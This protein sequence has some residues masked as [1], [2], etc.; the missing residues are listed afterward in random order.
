VL[1]VA[2]EAPSIAA[3]G[4]L[5][6]A[7]HRALP[8]M[9]SG[10]VERDFAGSGVTLRGWSCGA[11]GT[12]R[13]TLVYLHGIADNRGS[14]VGTIRKYTTQG[15]D[16]VA[17]DSRAHGRSGGE[18]CTYGYYEKDDLRRVIDTLP[19]GRVILMGTSLGAAVAIQTAAVDSRV[20]GVI[21]AE[22]FSNLEA[23]ARERVPFFLSERTIRKAFAIAESRGAFRIAD[24][25]PQEAARRVRVP[26]LLVHGADDRETLPAHSERVFEA[27]VGPKRLIL[28]PGAG[29]NLSLSD[30]ATWVEIDTWL[31]RYSPPPLN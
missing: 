27:L 13:G 6:P 5:Y 19:G 3:G 15:F 14:G 18:I 23:V 2:H 4:L 30:P 17:Y 16:V 22:V 11:T 28:T 8:E 26:V 29:H 10:C 25:S 12:R 21:A 31:R 24:V 20:A 9:P 7:R 1:A